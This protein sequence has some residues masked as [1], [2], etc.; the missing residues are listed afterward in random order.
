[1]PPPLTRMQP[2]AVVRVRGLGVSFGGAPVL[3]NLDFEVAPGE[4][5]A[6]IGPTGSGKTVLFRA[7]IGA[8]A[9][10]GEIRWAAGA[11]VGYVPQ[12]L[13]IER[14]LPVSGRDLLR[15]KAHVGHGSQEEIGDAL[16]LVN[17][18]P[19]IASKPL[20]TL[21]GGQFQ[22]LLLAFAFLG[23]PNVLLFDEATA[24][25]DEPG[26]ERLY[27]RIDRLKRERQLTLLLIS[28]ELSLVYRYATRVLCLGHGRS[29]LG[30]PIEVLT[31]ERLE[32]IYGS[33]MK[34]HVHR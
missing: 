17:L 4:S 23:R 7:L 20:G 16:E 10:T 34:Y 27:E 2:S 8:L 32:A 33:P 28:H 13:D 1:M 3:E 5:L 14:D 11:K 6:I 22:R 26:E 15:A 31:P 18:P 29:Y 21:S 24:G 12:K 9:Y 19:D 25:V 30:T